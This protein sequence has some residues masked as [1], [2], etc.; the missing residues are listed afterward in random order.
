MRNARHRGLE[1]SQLGI[2]VQQFMHQLVDLRPDL[3]HIDD[4]SQMSCKPESLVALPE[5]LEI[6]HPT[7]GE[8]IGL[9]GDEMPLALAQ[10]T[11]RNDRNPWRAI[12]KYNIDALLRFFEKKSDL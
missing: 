9:D 4:N 1:A 5:P 6:L 8:N 3:F 10:P 2:A 7:D 11:F 12:D